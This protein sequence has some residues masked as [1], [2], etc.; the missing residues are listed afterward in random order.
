MSE[1]QGSTL[2]KRVTR[3]RTCAVWK[4]PCGASYTAHKTRKRVFKNRTQR[5]ENLFTGPRY[6]NV[7]TMLFFENKIAAYLSQN[8]DHH[9]VYR[10]TPIYHDDD[11]VAS[12]VQMEAFSLEDYGG[13]ICFNVYLY[14]VQPGVRIDYSTGNSQVDEEYSPEAIISAAAAY[15]GITQDKL[16]ELMPFIA[17]DS[18]GSRDLPEDSGEEETAD[19]AAAETWDS[20]DEGIDEAETSA[21]ISLE[22]TEEPSVRNIEAEPETEEEF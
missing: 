9:V 22:E 14:N 21:K 11:L 1:T 2:D 13:S 5:Q 16:L 10:V 15:T 20:L 3:M 8:P 18:A 12:G 7:E 19:Q 6:L 4:A 17:E